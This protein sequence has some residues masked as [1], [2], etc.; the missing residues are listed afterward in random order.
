LTLFKSAKSNVEISPETGDPERELLILFQIQRLSNASEYL[1][2][3]E[4]LH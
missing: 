4:A 1:M 3:Y 2:T